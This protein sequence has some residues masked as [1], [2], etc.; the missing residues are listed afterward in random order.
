M[1][2]LPILP[3]EIWL[4]IY[5]FKRHMEEKD[6]W[7]WHNEVRL[8]KNIRIYDDNRWW[9]ADKR[10]SYSAPWPDLDRAWIIY[11]LKYIAVPEFIE[12]FEREIEKNKSNCYPEP[13]F[14]LERNESISLI[15]HG[16]YS[17]E[18]CPYSKHYN[19]RF[20]LLDELNPSRKPQ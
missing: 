10:W 9:V 13:G 8:S 5:N 7:G 1:P 15:I 6:H 20:K 2:S 17:D 3:A 11:Y 12:S 4:I 19:N 14:M 18:N 16:Y